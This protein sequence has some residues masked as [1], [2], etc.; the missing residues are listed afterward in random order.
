MGVR[1]RTGSSS[2]EPTPRWSSFGSDGSRGPQYHFGPTPRVAADFDRS[3]HRLQTEPGL[4]RTEAPLATRLLDRG[5]DRVTLLHDRIK[6]RHGGEW[7]EESIAPAD[8]RP[9]WGTGLD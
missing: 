8:W 9:T 4:R 3:S 5:P 1:A 6:F 2:T 7:A